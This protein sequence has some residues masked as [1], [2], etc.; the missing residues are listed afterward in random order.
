MCS[1]TITDITEHSTSVTI[2]ITVRSNVLVHFFL[3]EEANYMCCH[4][5]TTCF[6]LVYHN[7]FLISDGVYS[8]Y[9]YM[10]C[11]RDGQ[12][13]DLP[14]NLGRGSPNNP[15]TREKCDAH[16]QGYLYFGL[17]VDPCYI[18]R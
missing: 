1:L 3:N 11:H 9:T 12:T 17:Q 18:I 16:C 6:C 10:G 2:Q 7:S 13:R 4:I 5:M 8:A 14:Y 15:M